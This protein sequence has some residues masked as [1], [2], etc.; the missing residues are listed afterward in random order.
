MR[1]KSDVNTTILYHVLNR[2][3][4]SGAQGDASEFE[5]KALAALV[6][7][8]GPSVLLAPLLFAIIVSF[9][10]MCAADKQHY[11]HAG[12]NPHVGRS[13]VWEWGLPPCGGLL[14]RGARDVPISEK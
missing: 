2:L 9:A 4:M 14:P 10:H 8:K 12:K 7:M 1:L 5:S 11:S 3:F 6:T 13:G